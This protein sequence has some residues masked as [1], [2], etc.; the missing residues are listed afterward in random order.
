MEQQEDSV[1]ADKMILQN[2]RSVTIRRKANQG[3]KHTYFHVLKNNIYM[4]RFLLI[5]DYD[6]TRKYTVTVHL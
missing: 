6:Y 5:K 2:L 4:F 3:T 1:L